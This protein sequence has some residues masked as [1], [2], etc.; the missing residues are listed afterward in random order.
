MAKAMSLLLCVLLF[1]VSIYGLGCAGRDP[2]PVAMQL[3]GDETLNCDALLLQKQQ[4]MNE[5]KTLKPKTNK[6]ATNTFWFIVL[7]FLMDVKDAEKV[8]YDAFKRRCDYLTTLMVNKGCAD[9]NE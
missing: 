3:P 9:V 2:N 6:F 8:E 4:C 1:G 7:P 5:M